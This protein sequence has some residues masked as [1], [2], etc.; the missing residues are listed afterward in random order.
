MKC[1]LHW[2][3]FYSIPFLKRIKSPVMLFLPNILWC[4]WLMIAAHSCF[5]SQAFPLLLL[6]VTL[7]FSFGAF[8]F[9]GKQC[10]VDFISCCLFLFLPQSTFKGKTV[11]T[12][13]LI[14]DLPFRFSSPHASLVWMD[15]ECSRTLGAGCCLWL[16]AGWVLDGLCRLWVSTNA[17]GREE[18]CCGW[19]QGSALLR[20][21]LNQMPTCSN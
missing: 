20:K 13:T 3:A 2:N 21:F 5:L 7:L 14:L 9:E 17:M 6:N 16:A 1:A 11:N 10:F 15:G 4:W 19:L 18:A 12:C 8:V